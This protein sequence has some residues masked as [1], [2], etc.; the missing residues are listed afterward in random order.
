MRFI[1]TIIDKVTGRA[2]EYRQGRIKWEVYNDESGLFKAY[3]ARVN[4][5][6]VSIHSSKCPDCL[7]GK[8]WSQFYI[9]KNHLFGSKLENPK[10]MLGEGP[11][12]TFA[13]AEEAALGMVGYDYRS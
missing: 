5:R 13:Q 7:G 8:W 12:D 2:R 6:H 3:S 4:G 11:Y 10:G 9:Y 1:A